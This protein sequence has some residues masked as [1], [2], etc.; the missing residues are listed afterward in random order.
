MKIVISIISVALLGA[1]ALEL[2]Q[3][4]EN[5]PSHQDRVAAAWAMFDEFEA[6]GGTDE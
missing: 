2:R 6:E 1:V 4:A 5:K 3:G